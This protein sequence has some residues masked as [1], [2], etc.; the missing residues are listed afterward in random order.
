MNPNRSLGCYALT[1]LL[2]VICN[3]A[4]QLQWN[5]IAPSNRQ[6][7]CS[8]TKS[9]IIITLMND[10]GSRMKFVFDNISQFRKIREFR[11]RISPG[12]IVMHP[13]LIVELFMCFD[14]ELSNQFYDFINS[15]FDSIRIFATGSCEVRLSATATLH[16]FSSFANHCTCIL[17]CLDEVVG[18]T[19]G[20]TWFASCNTT[21]D[22]EQFFGEL[23]AE[24]ECHVFCYL[25]INWE[26]TR[27][28][29]DAVDIGSCCNEIAL[30]LGCLCCL[31]FISPT[32][33]L[34]T[35]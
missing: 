5:P 3:V 35:V 11:V 9:V 2:F 18:E 31:E 26:N 10:L 8:K 30:E 33:S 21:N 12:C 15:G 25:S 19:Y 29:L 1:S 20:Q 28:D 7:I 27:D 13:G 34:T 32:N 14:A 17:A 24:L 23:A 6:Y 22:Y 16:E 4:F